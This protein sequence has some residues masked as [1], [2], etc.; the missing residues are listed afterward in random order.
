MRKTIRNYALTT[1][2]VAT[3]AAP[4]SAAPRGGGNA[5]DGFFA[6]LRNAIIRALDDAKII[7]PPG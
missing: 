6:K 1:L 4:L 7:F 5:P 2:M 3:L